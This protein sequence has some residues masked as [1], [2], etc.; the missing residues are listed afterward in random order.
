M[1]YLTKKHKTDE[2][3]IEDEALELPSPFK[4]AT[5]KLV[6][7]LRE[8]K[9]KGDFRYLYEHQIDAV[10]N[11]RKHL[12]KNPPDKYA[13]IVLP[14]G[15]GKTRVAVVASYAVDVRKVLVITPF[16]KMS[17]HIREAFIGIGSK[18]KPFMFEQGI[19][20]NTDLTCIP[21]CGWA[22][23]ASEV[24]NNLQNDLLI[25]NPH[26]LDEETLRYIPRDHYDLV[27]VVEAHHYPARTWKVPV[28]Y[29]NNSKHIFLT[30]TP[31]HQGKRILPKDHIC[32]EMTHEE[33][34]AKGI[35]RS[36]RFEEVGSVQDEFDIFEVNN[37]SLSYM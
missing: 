2:A 4:V 30:A 32:Y 24:Q 9:E 37:N 31:F 35:I 13:I 23:T 33:A 26:K 36:L 21:S 25:V 7:F 16:V 11:V 14:T 17:Q 3:V 5:Q 19:M 29:F 10:L 34:V 27:I 28:D 22:K 6:E 20:T 15:C 1:K 18:K 12:E 8:K